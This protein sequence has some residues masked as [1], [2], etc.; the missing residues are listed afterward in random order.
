MRILPWSK[1]KATRDRVI[2]AARKQWVKAFPDTP[3]P[4]RFIFGCRAYYLR[5][6]G[7]P[8]KN[9]RNIYDDAIAVVGPDTFAMFNANTDPSPF[10]KGVATLLAG[11]HPY[12]FGKHGISTPSGGYPAMRPNTKGE[13]LPV[14]RDGE[15]K[16]PSETPGVAINIHRGGINTTSSLGCQTVHPTQWDAF[17]NLAK[18]EMQ[19][20]P[21][22]YVLV[23]GP[24][25]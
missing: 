24:I 8:D 12:R 2:A 11:V 25:S 21:F 17:Y 3:L 16:V 10:R 20:K 18:H 19:G 22:Y 4:E 6:M 7:N 1:P 23:D 5:T 9:D 14:K 13:E 15:D